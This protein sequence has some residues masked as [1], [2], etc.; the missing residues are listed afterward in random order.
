MKSME[1]RLKSLHAPD[2]QVE[3]HRT[4]LRYRLMRPVP[5]RVPLYRRPVLATG[6]AML[7]LL[8]GLTAVH[9]GWAEELLNLVLV[10]RTQVTMSDG[11][12]AEVQ[13]YRVNSTIKSGTTHLTVGSDGHV[14]ATQN[15]AGDPAT[16][17]I[18]TESEAQIRSGQA[19][20]ILEQ[21]G[22]R[23]YKVTLHDGRVI[24]YASGPGTSWSVS[25]AQ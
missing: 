8:G 9:P 4:Q 23:F 14:T 15:S 18:H 10:S 22:M 3:T 11:R 12:K 5:V 17:A 16:E 6:M 2:V 19:K 13:T 7:L 24:T 20:L 1:D 21:N 25:T